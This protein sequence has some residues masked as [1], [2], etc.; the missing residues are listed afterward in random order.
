MTVLPS[1]CPLDCPDACSLDV[2]VEDGRV[3]KVDGSHVNPV[4]EGYICSK[5]RHFPEHLYSDLR[6]RK[7]AVR[8]GPKGSGRFRDVSWDEALDLVAGKLVAVRDTRGGEAILP[9][10][11][12]GSNGMLTQSNTDTRLFHR[13]GAS[14][15]LRTVCA[16][17][18]TRAAMGLYGR[19]VGVAIP[20]YIHAQLIV[21]W[22]V[23]PHASGIHLVPVIQEAQKN[24]ARLVVVDPTTTPLAARADLH[25]PI[26][27]GTDLP[28]ALSLIRFLFEEG[29]ADT[30][31][32][33]EHAAETETLS[34]RASAW[35]FE[36]AAALAGV[37]V[38]DLERLGD[39]Y[40]GA[41]PAVIRCGWG[42]ERNRNGG[43]AAA[44][45]MALPAVAGK[46]GV[47][48]GG[49]TMSNGSAFSMGQAH[50]APEPDT[51]Q[52]NMNRL[53]TTLLDAGP[54]RIDCLFVYNCNPLA[55]MPDQENVRK[56]LA[57]EDLFT[58]VFDQVM[59][60]SALFADVLLPA[61]TFLEHH[62]MARGY[63]A[64]VLQE[65]APVIPP[66]GEAR[67]NCDVF[68][69]LCRRTGVARPGDPETA[70]EITDAIYAGAA[71][72]EALRRSVR[73]NGFALPSSGDRPVQ[74]VD[75][76]PNTP[77]RKVHLCPKELDEEA[78]HGLYHYRE[79]PATAAFPL[80]LISPA[81]RHTVS[82]YFGQLL[83][84]PGALVMNEADAR[85]RGLA[86]GDRIRVWNALGEMHCRVAISAAI[87]PGVVSMPKGLWC[88]HTDNGNTTNALS[89]AT[90]TDLGD[91]AC[92][93][94]ARVQVEKR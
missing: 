53:G 82:S 85:P 4:T 74:F 76:F 20:D 25:L 52:I 11:Y 84:K 55:T 50:N 87:R 65:A 2:T 66:V 44:A 8:T 7:P 73:E 30:S 31:F 16:V 35:T 64:M 54:G 89:P 18:T 41:K 80:A 32:L 56:G 68:A 93:N 94:D 91:G 92:F 43:S 57:R 47:R 33:A 72:G 90:Y 34:E 48:G 22:G 63:G 42:L 29:H 71:N 62:E 39:W 77:D 75:V 81:S 61:T 1:V 69:E 9:F 6:I 88:R 28:V 86:D 26:R 27:P 14:R 49:Y 38:T 36:R 19:M 37:P 67:P 5:V 21:V 40:A 51:R 70:G 83:K 10:Y 13:L 15:L 79:D 59:T 60:D 3:V 23:N 12:G 58:V 78:P 17:P 45:V 24:G 46:F